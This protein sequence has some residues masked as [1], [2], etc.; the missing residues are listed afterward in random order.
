MLETILNWLV[1]LV[2]AFMFLMFFYFY[3]TAPEK[4]DE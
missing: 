2:M 1:I 4:R 3:V